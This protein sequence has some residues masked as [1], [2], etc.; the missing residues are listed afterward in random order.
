MA[1]HVEFCF[2]LVKQQPLAPWPGGVFLQ[3]REP[4]QYVGLRVTAPGHFANSN[5]FDSEFELIAA[6][7]QG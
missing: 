5:Y 2:Q 1:E 6:F 3:S 4:S 7:D